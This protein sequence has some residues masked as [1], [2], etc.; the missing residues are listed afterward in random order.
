[1]GYLLFAHR[2]QGVVKILER[3][4]IG[5]LSYWIKRIVTMSQECVICGSVYVD[6]ENLGDLD[7]SIIQP[8]ASVTGVEKDKDAQSCDLPSPTK[9]KNNFTSQTAA[10]HLTVR[11]QLVDPFQQLKR[12]YRTQHTP[13]YLLHMETHGKHV[14]QAFI[15]LPPHVC[16]VC[17]VHH[18]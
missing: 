12:V 18:Q 8:R 1:M 3:S 4:V 5:T 15:Q 7:H 11:S 6:E 14:H 13:I 9:L 17:E 16:T 10:I 2:N